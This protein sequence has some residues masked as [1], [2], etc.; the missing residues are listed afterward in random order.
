MKN[1]LR[2]IKLASVSIDGHQWGE[3]SVAIELELACNPWKQM[4]VLRGRIR[5]EPSAGRMTVQS[6]TDW[7]T[8]KTVGGHGFGHPTRVVIERGGTRRDPH[9]DISGIDGPIGTITISELMPALEGLS[10]GD[11]VVVTFGT[12]LSDIDGSSGD[13]SQAELASELYDTDSL[14]HLDSNGRL[15][16]ET[17]DRLTALHLRAIDWIRQDAQFDAGPDGYVEVSSHTLR[18]GPGK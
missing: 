13:A 15:K 7:Q 2:T 18:I 1:L 5:I 11:Q 10:P 9:L 4:T 17:T 6:F 3:G 14:G 12:W 8:P 16:T